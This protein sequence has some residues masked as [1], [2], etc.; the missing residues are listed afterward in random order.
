MNYTDEQLEGFRKKANELRERMGLS[1]NLPISDRRFTPAQ[2]N[3]FI[4]CDNQGIPYKISGRI[5]GV[6]NVERVYACIYDRLHKIR[7]LQK[8]KVLPVSD[9]IPN[10]NPQ[11]SETL[12]GN[13]NEVESLEEMALSYPYSQEEI[14]ADLIEVIRNHEAIERV[15]VPLLD[16]GVGAYTS[17]VVLYGDRK[18]QGSE[19]DKALDIFSTKAGDIVRKVE[20]LTRCKAFPSNI[21]LYNELQR[22]KAYAEAELARFAPKKF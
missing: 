8:S 18:A 20:K 10:G 4:A 11:S 12:D 5:M 7:K 16:L 14:D 21:V 9:N 1:S 6:T 2:R 13:S 3:Y 15:I 22:M 17:I 19:R